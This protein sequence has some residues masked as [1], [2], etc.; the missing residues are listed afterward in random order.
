MPL[1]TNA[2]QSLIAG[3]WRPHR[4]AAAQLIIRWL[5]PTEMMVK[6]V[7]GV[8]VSSDGRQVAYTVTEAA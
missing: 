4:L 1:I 5:T 8:Q 6:G 3:G 2:T 7:G